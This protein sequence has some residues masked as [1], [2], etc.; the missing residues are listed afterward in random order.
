MTIKEKIDL[1]IASEISLIVGNDEK[2]FARRSYL[3]RKRMSLIQAIAGCHARTQDLEAQVVLVDQDIQD[4]DK[5][6]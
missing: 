4:L 6:V 2:Q 1:E 5:E 3:R